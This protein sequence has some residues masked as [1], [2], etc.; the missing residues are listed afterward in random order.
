MTQIENF[1]KQNLRE[2]GTAID[3]ALKEIGDQYGI[4]IGTGNGSFNSKKYTTKITAIIG[5]DDDKN[6]HEMEYESDWNKY[7]TLFDLEKEW[8]GETVKVS[9]QTS[10]IIIGLAPKASVY[11]VIVKKTNGGLIKLTKDSIIRQMG[12]T[13][14]IK[15]VVQKP[16]TTPMND[17]ERIVFGH[18]TQLV[19]NK[20]ENL[21]SMQELLKSMEHSDMKDSSIMVYVGN[22]KKKNKVTRDNNK[23]IIVINSLIKK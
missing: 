10:G 19:T 23:N 1:N 17:N 9:S 6:I 18:I 8:L 22:L 2:L 7:H 15:L 11:P 5:N 3:K 12:T 4:T 21:I 13:K 16:Q 14:P 20:G